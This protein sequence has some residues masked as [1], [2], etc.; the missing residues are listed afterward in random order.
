MQMAL[1]W[2]KGLRL[3]SVLQELPASA[4]GQVPEEVHRVPSGEHT[5]A[6][7]RIASRSSTETN[8]KQSEV[9]EGLIACWPRMA[10]SSK[11]LLILKQLFIWSWLH[12]L[13]QINSSVARCFEPVMLMHSNAHAENLV[14]GTVL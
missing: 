13:K 12:S 6:A 1:R 9:H 7:G 8:N 14:T 10:N 3:P 2:L 5:S 11:N 4:N